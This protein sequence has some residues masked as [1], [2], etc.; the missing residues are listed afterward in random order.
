M[1]RIYFAL[2]LF[3]VTLLVANVVVGLTSGDINS[4]AA[5]YR[6]ELASLTEVERQEIPGEPPS[7]KLLAARAALAAQVEAYQPVRSRQ[8]L[9]FLLGLLAALVTLLLNSISL[10]YFIGTG[11]W[12]REVVEAYEL[13]E[14]MIERSK[15]I[16]RSNYPWWMCINLAL[17]AIVVLGGASDPSANTANSLSWVLPHRLVA[18]AGTFMIAWAF[19]RQVGLVGKHYELID[20]I[21]AVVEERKETR[22]ALES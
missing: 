16:K 10:T 15:A 20:E 9:H 12:C 21:L 22:A 2:G 1:S 3:S 4:E 13:D 6:A 11:R 8:T 5:K 7:E 18:I 19:L 17:L 14:A